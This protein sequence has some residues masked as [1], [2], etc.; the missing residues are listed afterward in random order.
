MRS[1][2]IAIESDANYVAHAARADHPSN[3]IMRDFYHPTL[4][5]RP[6]M[7]PHILGLTA[8]P[9][10][11]SAS[12]GIE[13]VSPGVSLAQLTG[14]REI[15]RNL[16]AICK[17]PQL[18]REQLIKHVHRPEMQSRYY[19][20]FAGELNLSVS[21]IR[22]TELYENL[23]IE[24]DPFVLKLKALGYHAS[25]K[26]LDKALQNKSTF[27]QK[28]VKSLT[29][30]AKMI[31]EELGSWAADYYISCCV[32]KI[33]RLKV[34][35][36]D[37]EGL[38][39]N[40]KE[41]L[42][43]IFAGSDWPVP[44]ADFVENDAR[45]SSKFHC[46]QDILCEGPNSSKAFAGLVF[47]QTRASVGVLAHLLSNHHRTKDVFKLGTF[48]GSSDHALRKNLSEINDIKSQIQTLDDLRTGKKNL[49]IATSV[50]EEGI[51][52]AACN[53]VVCFE[54]PQNLKS[55]IQRRGRARQ[56][57]SKY[58]VMFASEFSRGISARQW[59]TLE[60]EM[61]EKYEDEMRETE[62]LKAIEDSE[63]GNRE[64]TIERTGWVQALVEY[65]LTEL[66][67]HSLG[68]RLLFTAQNLTSLNSVPSSLPTNTSNR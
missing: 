59:Q 39:Y 8:S 31:F 23:D 13:F 6:K 2:S 55:F 65:F 67:S 63:E 50:L 16:N 52:I 47:T 66:I 14:L 19:S 15:E 35:N 24:K 58:I 68:Q 18:H 40:E 54:K 46:L 26:P 48:V 34:E 28:Q 43:N 4:V 25:Y 42:Q 49:I 30:T 36:F 22:L 51:D 57:N 61:K 29:T 11:N 56:S 44:E 17:T 33:Q 32:K 12:D 27:C 62:R 5:R 7:V 21:L 64:Y 10:V 1:V 20:K 37:F 45:L 3:R 60:R 9:V 53:V 38:E 41:Y